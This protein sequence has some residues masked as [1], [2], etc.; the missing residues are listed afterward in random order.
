MFG[1]NLFYIK[2]HEQ[3]RQL[4]ESGFNNIRVFSSE[5]GEEIKDFF[6][7]E[8]NT[9]MYLYYLCNINN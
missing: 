7:L 9:E 2:P 6:A 8:N 1:L 4:Y 5:N 3:I